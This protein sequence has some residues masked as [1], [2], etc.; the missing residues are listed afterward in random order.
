M[1]WIHRQWVSESDL[2]DATGELIY[3]TLVSYSKWLTERH[4]TDPDSGHVR[5]FLTED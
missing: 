5:A 4:I 3:D 1:P 2:K